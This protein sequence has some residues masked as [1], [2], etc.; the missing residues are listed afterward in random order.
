MK[1]RLL[2]VLLAVCL[3]LTLGTV[4]AL[5]DDTVEEANSPE[6]LASALSGTASTIKL[7]DDIT[8]TSAVTISREVTIDLNGHKLSNNETGL[9]HTVVVSADGGNLTVIDSGSQSGVIDNVVHG[10]AALVNY[11][12]AVLS[13]GTFDR[14][15][16]AGCYDP[17]G[18]GGNSYYTVENYGTM[19][20]N[21]GVT[22]QQD[23]T[24][25]GGTNGDYSSL[26]HN[27][28]AD[29]NKNISKSEAILT[30]MVERFLADSTL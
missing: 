5:A 23:G 11:G 24:A 30:I 9:F 20:I 10:K 8:V 16:E 13:G 21:D 25:N 4:S 14:S 26:L 12:T 19:I 17:Y 29:G 7:T 22:I 18:N 6:T 15:H 1:K 2:T 28:W 27:G 3:V